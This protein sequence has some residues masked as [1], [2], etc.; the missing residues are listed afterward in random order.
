MK[1]R[2]Y[3]EKYL[4]SINLSVLK[5]IEDWRR[6]D[7]TTLEISVS[8]KIDPDIIDLE[9]T[10]EIVGRKTRTYATIAGC[11][12]MEMLFIMAVISWLG[13]SFTANT[14]FQMLACVVLIAGVALVIKSNV[15]KMVYGGFSCELGEIY[16]QSES[17][18]AQFNDTL[19][20][21][22]IRKSK[23][24]IKSEEEGNED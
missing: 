11:V 15:E 14:V 2:Y 6:T 1:I 16:F 19:S 23:K 24:T 18:R 7:G 5:P 10:R 3:P 21:N 17:E 12:F 20:A 22:R 4:Q 13:K 9:K 8:G